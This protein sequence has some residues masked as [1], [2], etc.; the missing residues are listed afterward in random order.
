M[1][2]LHGQ[3]L[4]TDD[5]ARL[6]FDQ[7]RAMLSTTYWSPG[8]SIEKVRAAAYGAALVVSAHLG[9]AVVGYLRVVGDRVTFAWLCDVFVHED[10]RGKGLARAMVNFALSHPDVRDTKRWLLATRDAHSVYSECGFKPIDS[11]EPWMIRGSLLPP[12]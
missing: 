3:Y 7:L 4:I 8:V 10:H 1:Q 6:D 11:A 5:R 12:T 9:D 2:I